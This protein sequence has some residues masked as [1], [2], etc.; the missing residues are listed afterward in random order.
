MT[1]PFGQ[2]I[3]VAVGIVEDDDGNLLMQRRQPD[4]ACAGDWEFPGGKIEAGEDPHAALARE[5]REEVSIAVRRSAP[6]I[7]RTH[8]YP[9]GTF[10]LHFVQVLEWEGVP[11]DTEGQELAWFPRTAPP[12]PRLLAANRS[13]WHQLGLPRLAAISSAETLGTKRFLK[14]WDGLQEQGVRMLQVR[15]KRLDDGQRAALLEGALSRRRSPDTIVTFNGDPEIAD[16]AGA[17]GVHLDSARLMRTTGRPDC[18]W[19]SASCHNAEE[20][21]RAGKV[22]A[23]FAYIGPVKRTASHPDAAPI[24]WEGFGELADVSPIPL[25]ALGGL[26]PTDLAAA[27]QHGA[28]GIAAIKAFF[29]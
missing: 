25:Y 20:L 1:P 21:T 24:G 17:S 6:W 23:D 10:D 5:L 11:R 2:G 28:H 27:R 7:R 16:R 12:P 9:H 18:D 13:F 3:P 14:K 29:G 4:R 8:T 15:D 19:V 26:T 22:G